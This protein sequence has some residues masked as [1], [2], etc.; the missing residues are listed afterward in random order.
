MVGRE[1]EMGELSAA[2]DEVVDGHGRIVMLAGEPG[3]GKT[4]LVEELAEHAVSKRVRVLWGRSFEGEGA[5]AYWP[6]IQILS[7]YIQTASAK[8]K[9]N[10]Q[11]RG[12]RNSQGYA[13]RAALHLPPRGEMKNL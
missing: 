5:P 9:E 4:R 2:L 10:S 6:W 11:G 13:R 7:S 3:I 12:K 1:R 8:V